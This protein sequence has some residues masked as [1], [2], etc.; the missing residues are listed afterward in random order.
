MPDGVGYVRIKYLG[1]RLNLELDRVLD[2]FRQQHVRSVVLDLR[3][4]EGALAGTVDAL[5]CFV[6]RGTP[7]ATL[8][9][10]DGKQPIVTSSAG[11]PVVWPVVV[12]VNRY[13][14]G[15]SVLLAGAL[16]D[17]GRAQVVGEAT[18]WRDQPRES[19]R[20][21]DGCTVSVATGYYTLPKGQVL[22]KR[23]QSLVPETVVPQEPLTPLGSDKDEQLKRA[24]DMSRV[25]QTVR[26]EPAR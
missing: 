16:R 24:V 5:A 20:L 21:A 11:N 8:V 4:N 13:S 1:E 25:Q 22:R 6:P 18:M 7:L 10:R 3:N 2:G 23:T 9:T 17:A 12:L 26:T 14:C 19:K 15:A